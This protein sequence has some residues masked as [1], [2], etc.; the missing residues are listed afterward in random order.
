MRS[1][2]W[3]AVP[4]S[5]PYGSEDRDSDSDREKTP[6]AVKSHEGWK[7]WQ[8]VVDATTDGVQ[9][10]RVAVQNRINTEDKLCGW[11]CSLRASLKAVLVLTSVPQNPMK[12]IILAATVTSSE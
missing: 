11:S 1:D 10:M 12:R 3:G 9:G 4:E 2:G 6:E 7:I 5:P 8:K